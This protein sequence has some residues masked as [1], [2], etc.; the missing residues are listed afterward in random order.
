MNPFRL[1]Q[2]VGGV[3]GPFV[4]IA[5]PTIVA[6]GSRDEALAA[7][8]T[9]SASNAFV[10][11]ATKTVRTQ[12]GGSTT[13]ASANA[14][15]VGYAAVAT[16][17]PVTTIP[18]FITAYTASGATIAHGTATG[19]ASITVTAGKYLNVVVITS[20]GTMSTIGSVKAI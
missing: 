15:V 6:P 5:T 3:A 2:T 12:L 11:S 16:A 7:V 17:S 14:D 18:D 1:F 9:T 20:D 4:G 19:N 13:N 10:I 8:V